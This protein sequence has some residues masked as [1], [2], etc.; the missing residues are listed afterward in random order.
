MFEHALLVAATP[1]LDKFP[2]LKPANLHATN[3]HR[4]A[5][6]GVAHERALVGAG[7]G[8]S[9]CDVG[10]V[11]DE[12]LNFDVQVWKSSNH[13][14]KERFVALGA[15]ALSRGRVVV[16]C[17]GGHKV[18]E[19]VEFSAVH[20]VTKLLLGCDIHFL[21]HVFTLFLDIYREWVCVGHG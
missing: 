11:G 20:G 4:F 5:A 21:T 9:E 6:S 16:N 12:T 18:V 2:V 8:L 14:A 17:V 1:P 13:L 19:K 3:R 7:E 10:I 15:R